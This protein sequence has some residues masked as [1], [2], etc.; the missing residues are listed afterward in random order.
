MFKKGDRSDI[1][2]YRP[3]ITIINNVAKVFEFAIFEKFSTSIFPKTH[4][5]ITG[6]NSASGPQLFL[7]KLNAVGHS[8]F[9]M[10]YFN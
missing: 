8:L 6:S 2:D 1:V 7:N 4:P 5:S 9:N 10:D 3:S